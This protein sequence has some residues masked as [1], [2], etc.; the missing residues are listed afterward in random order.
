M[1]TAEW[2]AN[3]AP[4][5]DPGLLAALAGQQAGRER[6]VAQRTRRVVQASLGVMKEQKAGRK[7]S[8]SLAIASAVV[9]LLALGPLLWRVADDLVE[10]DLFTDPATQ[11]SLLACLL[12]SAVAAA[13][14][15][16]GW[17]RRN[18]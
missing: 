18:F 9:V 11:L 1:K 12:C 16:A 17:A 10:G 5:S 15:V 4:S 3:P 13:V 7:R 6:A 14:L 8:R 2:T